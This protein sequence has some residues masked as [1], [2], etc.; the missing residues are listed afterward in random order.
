M[1]DCSTLLPLLAGATNCEQTPH[2]AKIETHCLYP[3][4][5]PVLVFVGAS[6]DN[7]RVTDAGGAS[8]SASVH[9]REDSAIDAGLKLAANY[10][11]VAIIDGALVADHVSADWLMAAIKAVA[12][13]SAMAA[14][15][16]VNAASS[17][18][19]ESLADKIRNVLL[20][21]VPPHR[22]ASDFEWRGHS[23]KLWRAHYGVTGGRILFIKA[24]AP[25]HVSVN[26]AY[27]AFS[28]IGEVD[29]LARIGVFDRELK[30]DDLNLI[31]QVGAIMPLRALESGARTAL[32]TISSH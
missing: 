12:N 9:A 32:Q 16:A 8:N 24:I 14:M 27:A 22:I 3:S 30:R 15:A 4:L 1:I 25:S 28:D 20:R 18:Q 6:G 2:G 17:A 19:E 10:H 21:I 26:G 31:A 23:G 29:E 5:D 7:F 11:G 13:A